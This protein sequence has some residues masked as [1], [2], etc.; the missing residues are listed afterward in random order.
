MSKYSRY[1]FAQPNVNDVNPVNPVLTSLSIGFKNEAFMWEMIAPV[2]EAN[3]RSATFPIY[4]R[5]NWFRR[6]G[7]AQR[8]AQGP[9][10]RVGYGVSTDT[11]ETIEIGFE[12]SLGDVVKA[13]NQFGDNL[14]TKDVAFLTNLIELEI[15]KQVADVV[16]VTGAWGN[17]A[18]LS[19]TGQWSDFAN[20]DPIAD[21]DTAKRTILRNTGSFVNNTFIGLLGW[22]KLKEHP[23]LLDKYKHTQTGVLTEELVAASLGI[24][25]LTVGMSVE[26]TADENQTYVGADIWTDNML[27]QVTNPEGLDVANS[28]YTIMWNERGNIPWAVESYREEQTRSDIN[29]VFTHLVPKITS[30]QHGY[31][32]LDT[33]A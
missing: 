16:F 7:G 25:M 13:S 20:S 22:E 12:K 11:Y 30:S 28:V 1:N 33:V 3:L 18:T 21:V 27:L 8:S 24:P 32:I 5:E 10:Q 6:Q 19:G 2:H 26:N 4:D 15:E 29:R 9:Y 17:E 23:L 31:L 14:E